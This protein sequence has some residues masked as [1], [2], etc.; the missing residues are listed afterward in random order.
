VKYLEGETMFDLENTVD[1]F[2]ENIKKLFFP[3]DWIELDMKFSK[4]ELFTMLFLDKRK[5]IT[6]TELVEYINSPMSTATGI[7]DRLVKNGYVS[8]ERS[9]T[10]RRIVILRPTE[11]GS[12]LIKKLKDI[13]SE[14]ISMVVEDL[15][16]EEKQFMTGIAFKIINRLQTKLSNTASSDQ[17]TNDIRKIEIE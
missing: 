15:T 9:E 1:L 3:E 17:N 12:Q 8:R 4:F 11:E 7:V 6:M 5:E 13:I 10:D 2:I 14:Y 16:E